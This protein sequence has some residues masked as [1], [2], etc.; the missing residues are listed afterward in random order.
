MLKLSFISIKIIM[1]KWSIKDSGI[2]NYKVWLIIIYPLLLYNI[3]PRLAH[4]L[5]QEYLTL[6]LT[7]GLLVTLS[8]TS[9]IRVNRRLNSY[10]RHLET[11][12]RE[13]PKCSSYKPKWLQLPPELE[14]SLVELYYPTKTNKTSLNIIRSNIHQME[15]VQMKIYM[16]KSN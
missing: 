12:S 1:T 2:L 5:Y 14:R 16:Q 4:L 7:L 8:L 9:W 6:L 10:F 11:V 13:N 15:K 3:H